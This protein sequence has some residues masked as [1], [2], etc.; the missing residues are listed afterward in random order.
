MA[1]H[2]SILAWRIP[3]TRWGEPGG[4]PSMGSHRVGHD[5]RDLA[6]AAA[7]YFL[8]ASQ[9][10]LVGKEPTYQCRRCKRRRFNPW[11]RK[12]PCS[13]AWQPTPA[14]LPGKS[15]GQTEPGKLQPTRSQRVRQD[16]TDLAC[17]HG[18]TV[19]KP[20]LRTITWNWKP[21]E[22]GLSIKEI[23]HFTYIKAFQLLNQG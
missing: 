4:L 2:S 12:M 19:P 13:R 23:N 10:T 15:H 20:F 16:W 6:A 18:C 7:A 1:T 3:G 17:M 21:G 11:V 5:W 22:D 9:V 8:R 14:F